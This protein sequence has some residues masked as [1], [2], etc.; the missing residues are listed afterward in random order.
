MHLDPANSL[1]WSRN[2]T[3]FTHLAKGEPL[4]SSLIINCH[5][6]LHTFL[7]VPFSY[8]TAPVAVTDDDATT[9]NESSDSGVM[10]GLIAHVIYFSNKESL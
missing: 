10:P 7:H 5:A 1:T 9:K 8:N 4:Q 3:S 2:C 6:N